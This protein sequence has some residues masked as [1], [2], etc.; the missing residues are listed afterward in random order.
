MPAI[1]HGRDKS[2]E[3][4]EPLRYG[5]RHVSWHP[6]EGDARLAAETLAAKHGVGLQIHTRSRVIYIDHPE[7]E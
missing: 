5:S 3:V 2:W 1:L 4:R 7:E 6:T